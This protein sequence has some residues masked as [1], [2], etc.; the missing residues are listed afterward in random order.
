MMNGKNGAYQSCK[1]VHAAHSPVGHICLAILK[2]LT[3]GTAAFA[4]QRSKA[5]MHLLIASPSRKVC[6]S[7]PTKSKEGQ[8]ERNQKHL[9]M[10]CCNKV[11]S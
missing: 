3:R 11:P 2:Y 8:N 10:N 7:H 5:K 4:G 1:G 9:F 6:R